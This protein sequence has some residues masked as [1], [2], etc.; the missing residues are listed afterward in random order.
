V[1]NGTFLR[2]FSEKLRPIPSILEFP[3]EKFQ[4]FGKIISENLSKLHYTC[5][6]KHFK[7]KQFCGKKYNFLSF[8]EDEQ[9]NVSSHAQLFEELSKLHSTKPED[10]FE[11]KHFL[12]ESMMTFFQS[13]LDFELQISRFWAEKT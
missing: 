7:K 4:T 6:K 3:A 13:V 12:M 1:S 8:S 5:S 10:C 9:T 11:T 2:F